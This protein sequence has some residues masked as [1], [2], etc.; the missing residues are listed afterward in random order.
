MNEII[1]SLML[2][3]GD[4]TR[5]DVYL[6]QPN[7]LQTTQHNMCKSYGI[8]HKER[9]ESMKLAAFYN[10]EQ[11]IYLKTNFEPD[12]PHNQSELLH[13][14]VHYIQWSNNLEKNYCLGQLEL[15]AYILQDKWRIQNGLEPLLDDFNRLML[16]AS[17]DE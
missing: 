16:A 1:L 13:E 11:T 8:D 5:Y 9:C 2:W 14:L 15:E 10:K 6:Q 17:C 7:I 12:N 3:V 4:H